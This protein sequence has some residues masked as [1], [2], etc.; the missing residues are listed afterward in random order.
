MESRNARLVALRV[1]DTGPSAG[2]RAWVARRDAG[3][4][5][6]PDRAGATEAANPGCLALQRGGVGRCRRPADRCAMDGLADGAT[7]DRRRSRRYLRLWC[8]RQRLGDA[9]AALRL[10]RVDD[11]SRVGCCRAVMPVLSSFLAGA[12]DLGNC[13]MLFYHLFTWPSNLERSGVLGEL[14]RLFGKRTGHGQETFR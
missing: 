7:L 11:S 9:R 1:W 12:V 8:Y 3:V 4:C 13:H 5:A 10:G 6:R 2:L 14:Y